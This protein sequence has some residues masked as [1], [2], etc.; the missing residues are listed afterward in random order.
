MARKFDCNAAR[1]TRATVL[2][3][4]VRKWGLPTP[5]GGGS[6]IREPRLLAQKREPHDTGRPVSLLRENELRGARVRVIRVAVV[7][8]FAV[9]QDHDVGV[10]L[11]CARLAE[12]RKLRTMVGS[13]F[14]GTTKLRQHDD[15]NVQLLREALERSRY[16]TQLQR[17]VLETTQC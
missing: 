2:R 9:D 12:V 4:I 11:E 17:E 8:V 3:I 6:Q 14:R 16:R 15:R 7:R 1:S 10:L 5:S 13:R